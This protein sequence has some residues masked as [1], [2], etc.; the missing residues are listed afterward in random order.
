MFDVRERSVLSIYE[1]TVVCTI[2]IRRRVHQRD[3]ALSFRAGHFLVFAWT[4]RCGAWRSRGWLY[5]TYY[6]RE[7]HCPST[8]ISC[9]RF[10]ITPLSVTDPAIQR[11]KKAR[12]R[13][14][15]LGSGEVKLNTAHVRSSTRHLSTGR[16]VLSLLT[17]NKRQ[18]FFSFDLA[19]QSGVGW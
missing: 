18:V 5:M 9:T 6:I 19:R 1:V 8:S 4:I 12:V 11:E 2:G 16:R 17:V 13:S 14:I 3:W 10:R 7:V 15:K